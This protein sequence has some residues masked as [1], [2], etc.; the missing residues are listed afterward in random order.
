MQFDLI[1]TR[2]HGMVIPNWRHAFPYS[3]RPKVAVTMRETVKRELGNRVTTVAT[4]V[5]GAGQLEL[6]DARVIE[7]T[8][9][10]IVIAGFERVLKIDVPYDYAQSW[11][12]YPSNQEQS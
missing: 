3:R 8:V 2:A 10:R 12:L 5:W 9:D 6:W 4:A 11:V 7:L 1:F